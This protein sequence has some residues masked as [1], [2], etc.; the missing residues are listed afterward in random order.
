MPFRDP[1]KK[2][3]H[4]RRYYREHR[5]GATA[6]RNEK[7]VIFSARLPESLTA[8]MR[9]LVDEGLA[10]GRYPWKSMGACAQA[11]L[12]KGFEGMAGDEFVDEMIPYLRSLSQIDGVGAHR[13]EAQA[14]LSRMKTEIRE[15]LAIKATSEA[16]TYFH[17][18][19]EGFEAM[20]PN[21]WRDWLIKEARRAFPQ[22]LKMKPTTLRI[23]PK[24]KAAHK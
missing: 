23:V 9:K 4:N 13:R 3:K 19:L 7:R 10:T 16:A 21:I 6:P 14:A 24:R 15:L 2:V 18:L 11:L 12:I 5:S 1:K 22:L 20:P 17:G 8:R